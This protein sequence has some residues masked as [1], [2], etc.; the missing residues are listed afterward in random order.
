MVTGL[1]TIYASQQSLEDHL[2]LQEEDQEYSG[3][4]AAAAVRTK[5]PAC[6][7]VMVMTRLSSMSSVE[8]EMSVG[9]LLW[10][11]RRVENVLL[12]SNSSLEDSPGCKVFLNRKLSPEDST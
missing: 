9:A 3:T 11:I 4:Y 10:N 12:G 2:Q 5:R 1:S 6:G 8:T 7:S